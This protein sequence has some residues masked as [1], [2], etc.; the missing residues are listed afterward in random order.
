MPRYPELSSS[1]EEQKIGR[2]HTPTN[3]QRDDEERRGQKKTA[4]MHR[5]NK[6]SLSSLN[7][8]ELGKV[9]FSTL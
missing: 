2:A 7:T 3:Y 5:E 8:T 9:A 4:L 1:L 6:F